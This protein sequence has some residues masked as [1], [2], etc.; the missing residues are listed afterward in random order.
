M[1][2]LKML[3]F[4][5]GIVNLLAG[6]HLLCANIFGDRLRHE[7]Y[8]PLGAFMDYLLWFGPVFLVGLGCAIVAKEKKA[9]LINLLYLLPIVILMIFD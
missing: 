5:C 7:H 1:F 9:V 6:I 3:A 4:T 8:G 2:K